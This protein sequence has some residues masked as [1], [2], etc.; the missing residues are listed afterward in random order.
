MPRRRQSR[1]SEDFCR[2][3]NSRSKFWEIRGGQAG[4]EE[5][6]GGTG[7]QRSVGTVEGVQTKGSSEL[8]QS[9]RAVSVVK[10]RARE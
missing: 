10:G 7:E 4:E 8:K 5:F 2:R 6:P 9:N 1:Y 3:Q